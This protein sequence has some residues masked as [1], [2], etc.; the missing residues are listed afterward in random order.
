[1]KEKDDKVFGFGDD[2][3]LKLGEEDKQRIE[4]AV[5]KAEEAVQNLKDDLFGGDSTN[6]G[7]SE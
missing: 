7:E 3:E 1:M 4:N 5:E 2:S 6:D